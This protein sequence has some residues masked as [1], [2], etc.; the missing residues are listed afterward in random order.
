MLVPLALM[1]SRFE[2]RCAWLLEAEEARLTSGRIWFSEAVV[3]AKA[4]QACVLVSA[5][6]KR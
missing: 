6:R 4:F 3:A 1:V 5:P 2:R